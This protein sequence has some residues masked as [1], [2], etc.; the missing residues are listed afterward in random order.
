MAKKSAVT[1]KGSSATAGIK[2]RLSEK[3]GELTFEPNTTER[4]VRAYIKRR[5]GEM[6][7]FRKGLGLE[8]K[9]A[10][11]DEE[12]I[13]HELDFGTTRKRFETDQ[14]TGLRSR[15][16][17]V[18]NITQRWRN[19]T[20]APTLLAKIQVAV[21]TII[22]NMPE[23]NIVPLLRKFEASV[24]LAYSLWKRN[25]QISDAKE[26][27]KLVVF[28][29]IKYGWAVQRTYPRVVKYNKRVL[30]SKDPDNPENDTYVD[31]ELTWYNDIDR[32][33]LDPFK[34]WIDELA[35]PYDVYS[36][37]EAYYELDFS[38]DAFMVEFGQYPNSKYVKQD[39]QLV[40][41]TEQKKKNRTKDS[42]DQKVRKDIVTVGFFESRHKDMYAIRIPKDD[43]VL[44]ISPLPNDD[45]YLSITHGMWLLRHS[46]LPYGVSLWEI[47]KANKQLYDKMK[48]MTMDQL[49]LSIMK[50]GFFSGT[51]TAVGDG[52]IEI[53]PG[54]ARQ[55]TSSTGKPEINWME[56][57]GPGAEAWKGLEAIS[58]MMDDDSGI[59]PTLEGDIT[60]KTLGEIRL[61]EQR[62]LKRL[63]T[64]LENIASL[65]DD[66][67]YLTLSW[68]GQVYSTPMVVDFTD[69][70]ELLAFE[71]ENGIDH[72]QGKLFGT[73]QDDGTIAGPYRAHYLPQLA[74]HLEDHDGKLIKSKDSKFFD[75][76]KD[77]QPNQLKGLG[78]RKNMM[79]KVIPRSLVDTNEDIAKAVKTEMFGQLVPL[80]S[81]PPEIASKPAQQLIK[82][83]EEDPKDW[84]PD[85][86]I[87][88]LAQ[89]PAQTPGA[90]GQPTPPGTPTA[91]APGA[92][93]LPGQP[94][95]P[96]PGALTSPNSTPAGPGG[97]QGGGGASS[98][99]PA[100]TVGT[101]QLNTPGTPAT[102]EGLGGMFSRRL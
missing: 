60:G 24:D 79:F 47:I 35:T 22:D 18:G 80:L 86:F 19:A 100:P 23:A 70:D 93:G 31:K 58:D 97:A 17:P 15:M 56:I 28:D 65:I 30:D 12:Y 73:P 33:R 27:L 81:M 91:G 2:A 14:D 49:V 88:Y 85:S 96:G 74:L 29:M 34:T 20:S 44:Y 11:A 98:V 36:T 78:Q 41:A 72:M 10:E 39:S 99:I 38:Y 51:N 7:D 62:A 26:K 1:D 82:M 43:I 52:M 21:S 69:E 83:N 37:N 71:K 64:P 45:G 6:Q 90:P 40:R 61:A 84:L 102:K 42:V 76:G 25:W 66:D 94:G 63:K 92:P 57:P 50:F 4:K 89:G 53:I 32:Q 101:P 8:K 13:P 16:V 87:Q 59:T 55:L 46:N 54:Q 68:M 77:I 5:V 75:V 48:N 9:W 95:A 3:D 67:A